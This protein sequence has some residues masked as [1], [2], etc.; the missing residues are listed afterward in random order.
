MRAGL[1][2]TRARIYARPDR[3]ALDSTLHRVRQPPA[4]KGHAM[5]K[6]KTQKRTLVLHREA[7]Q[8]LSSQQ[9]DAVVGAVESNTIPT[10]CLTVKTCASFEFAC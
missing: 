2:V 7:I 9:L 3:G 1:P 4:T 6:H 10:L 5:K 8:I